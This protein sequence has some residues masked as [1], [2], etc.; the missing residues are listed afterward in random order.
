L[1]IQN[2]SIC[3]F[4]HVADVN[5]DEEEL[6]KGI[7]TRSMTNKIK[8]EIPCIFY[9]GYQEG[10]FKLWKRKFEDMYICSFLDFK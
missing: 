1:C 10:D 5:K 9:E 6:V 4:Y 3:L 8:K 7:N 2:I